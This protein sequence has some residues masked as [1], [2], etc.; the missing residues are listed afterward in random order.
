MWLCCSFFFPICIWIESL[1]KFYSNFRWNISRWM[2]RI[3]NNLFLK[4]SN[5]NLISTKLNP[6]A[7]LDLWTEQKGVRRG[8][9]LDIALN[10]KKE[11]KFQMIVLVI[12]GLIIVFG[13]CGTFI[14][15]TLEK[16][17]NWMNRTPFPKRWADV[18]LTSHRLITLVPPP[19]SLS[20]LAS[21]CLLYLIQGRST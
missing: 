4:K 21:S 1:C 17:T 13:I 3:L 5:G 10:T 20:I 6:R 12:Q 7:F 19:P 9:A 14:S 2:K 8:R 18:G 15:T 11:N 16:K